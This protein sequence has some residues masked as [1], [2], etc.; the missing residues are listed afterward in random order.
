MMS[1]THCAQ[2]SAL[3]MSFEEVRLYW[4]KRHAVTDRK[5]CQ[6]GAS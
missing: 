1:M 5:Y 2:R 3:T 4:C 6:A